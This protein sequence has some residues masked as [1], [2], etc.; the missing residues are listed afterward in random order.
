MESWSSWDSPRAGWEKGDEKGLVHTMAMKTRQNH[1]PSVL[2]QGT[3]IIS[4]KVLLN[5]G[6]LLKPKTLC[7]DKIDTVAWFWTSVSFFSYFF[8]RGLLPF[9]A[10]VLLLHD[11]IT[12]K[13]IKKW[14]ILSDLNL[15]EYTWRLFSRLLLRGRVPNLTQTFR[16]QADSN[17]VEHNKALLT[18]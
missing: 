15:T 12:F 11:W 4:V 7:K 5:L 6:N 14:A 3:L 2:T 17:H 18:Y 10:P 16:L 9:L 8:H 1:A 13:Y